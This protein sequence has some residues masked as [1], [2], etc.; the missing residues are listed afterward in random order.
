MGLRTRNYALKTV[1]VATCLAMWSFLLSGHRW[2]TVPGAWPWEEYLLADIVAGLFALAMLVVV[3]AVEGSLIWALS[4]FVPF[5]GLFISVR[6]FW[7]IGDVPFGRPL[8]RPWTTGRAV[9]SS[10]DED[11]AQPGASD[12]IT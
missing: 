11:V 3:R 5:W 12:E 2:A 6:A 1:T 7:L 10:S 4:I 9:K 8:P